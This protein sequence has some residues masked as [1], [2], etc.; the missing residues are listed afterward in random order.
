MLA[1][2]VVIS[3]IFLSQ[4]FVQFIAK[5]AAGAIEVDAII[6]I[7][8]LQMP[9]LFA[10]LLPLAIYLATLLALG[11]MY[12]DHEFTILK[13]CGIS[14][15][16]LAKKLFIPLTLLVAITAYLTFYIA[17]TAAY[18]QY[19]LLD[20]QKAQSQVGLLTAGQF[21]QTKDNRGTFYVQ[22]IDEQKNMQEVFYA[23]KN[24]EDD[25]FSL[26][27]AKVGS[28]VD[29]DDGKALVLNQGQ[30]YQGTMGSLAMT[31]SQFERYI[32]RVPEPKVK[33]RKYKLKAIDSKTLFLNDDGPSKA[34]LQWRLSVPISLLILTLIAIPL[35]RVRP[36]QGKF[37]KLIPAIMIYMLYMVGMLGSKSL[38]ESGKLPALPGMYVVHVIFAGYAVYLYWKESRTWVRFVKRGNS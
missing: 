23:L 32:L 15:I 13:A 22:N 10:F 11:R 21:K 37:A 17:P 38:I 25:S 14:E 30:Q 3:L 29:T 8:W 7:L 26:V 5:A 19:V 20:K 35:A 18:D 33:Q 28:I 16:Q 31:V 9:V 27:T 24:P 12:V 2:L 36:R 6:D 4:R 1:V 34:E